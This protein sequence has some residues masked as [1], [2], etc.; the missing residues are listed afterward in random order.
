MFRRQALLRSAGRRDPRQHHLE[1][2][3]PG[4]LARL[5][6]RPSGRRGGDGEL[7]RDR[8]RDVLLGLLRRDPVLGSSRGLPGERARP[9]GR[10]P[11][12]RQSRERG[13]RRECHDGAEC[14]RL[15]PFPP[16]STTSPDVHLDSTTYHV[17]AAW[18]VGDT[19]V[20]MGSDTDGTDDDGTTTDCG[21]DPWG[22]TS[23]FAT[24]S[25]A[26][27]AVPFS[28]ANFMMRIDW[29]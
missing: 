26:T 14:L 20:W 16:P 27:N 3:E 23:Y 15:G 1:G 7:H 6:Q 13:A 2:D 24:S 10:D 8:H 11:G 22:R 9:D 12:H 28:A 5:V 19:C 25:Y 17:A 21:D 4:R 18:N 29:Q